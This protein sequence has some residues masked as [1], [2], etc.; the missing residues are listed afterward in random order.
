MPGPFFFLRKKTMIRVHEVRRETA[1]M[2]QLLG[3]REASVR[4]TRLFLSEQE[5]RRLRSDVPQALAGVDI[6]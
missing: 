6:C 2:A 1:R 4:A 3:V 5:I